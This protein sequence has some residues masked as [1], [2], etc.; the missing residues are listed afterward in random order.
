MTTYILQVS[1]CWTFL[2][3]IYY[4]ILRKETFFTLNRFYLLGAL[5]GGLVLPILEFP[6][7]TNN[8]VGT[9]VEYYVS[10]ITVSVEQIGYSVDE[11]IITPDKEKS[12]YTGKILL[13]FYL[14]GVILLTGRFLMGLFH[15]ARL[16]NKSS[17]EQKS[18]YLLIQTDTVHLPFSF[19]NN[20]FWSNKIQFKPEDCQTILNHEL[21]HIRQF[22]SIDIICLKILN[23]LFWF[24]PIIWFYQE[25]IK[26][27]HEYLADEHVVKKIKKKQYGQLLLRQ[28]QSGTAFSFANNFNHSQLKKR[29]NMMNK[30]KSSN[31]ALTKYLWALPVLAILLIAF[32]N[33]NTTDSSITTSS[34]I[35][36]FQDTTIY[37]VVDQ[38]PM[39][40]GCED[41]ADLEERQKC[42]NKKM[43]MHLYSQIKYP[44]LAHENGTEGTTVVRFVVDKNGN[45]TNPE[46]VRTIGDGCDEEVLRIV[47]TFPQWHPGIHNGKKVAVYFNLPV[48]FKLAGEDKIASASKKKNIEKLKNDNDGKAFSKVDQMPMF[49]GC[50]DMTDLEERRNCANQK[51]LMHIYKNITYPELARE[52][53]T[54]GTVVVR[55]I[56]NKTGELV[57]PEI[58]RGVGNGCDVEVL[59]VVE[60]MP[61]WSPGIHE[62]KNVS[63]YFNLPVKF[64]LEDD[65]KPITKTEQVNQKPIS[66]VVS[67]NPS[68]GIV[69]LQAYA[70]DQPTKLYISDMTGKILKQFEYPSMPKDFQKE[71]DLKALGAS[72]MTLITIQ[73]NNQVKTEKILVQ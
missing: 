39:F 10:P 65:K 18:D 40:P 51:M 28:V 41:I 70:S 22:H 2:Y 44:K 62:G 69:N 3:L 13:G 35:T 34:P 47:E 55:F 25:A 23:I 11:I 42:S 63:T 1:I 53:G 8:L 9:N 48:K 7:L 45:I 4:L 64:K 71:L 72:G 29:F 12:F 56:I 37:K 6:L 68:T 14:I 73:Q 31:W 59:R 19:F 16:K 49:P 20:L 60:T 21:V 54:Q 5:L 30:N 58:I 24:N 15:I 67:P 26:N 38:M 50:E 52:T 61:I 33:K 32:T 43:L 57:E 36:D 27:T 66:F 17:I 46:M